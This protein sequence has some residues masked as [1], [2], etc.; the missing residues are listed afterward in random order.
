MLHVSM[1]EL[2]V[3]FNLKNI[4]SKICLLKIQNLKHK[5]GAAN[6]QFPKKVNGEQFSI[7]IRFIP[8]KDIVVGLDTSLRGPKKTPTILNS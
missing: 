7:K 6:V 5:Y 4:F 8:P 2:N 1:I 3:P